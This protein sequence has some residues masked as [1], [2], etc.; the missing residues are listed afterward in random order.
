MMEKTKQHSVKKNFFYS[1]ILTV[2]NYLFPMIVFPYVSRVLGVTNIG[3]CNFVDSIVNYFMLFSMMGITVMGIREI[4]SVKSDRMEMSRSF[5]SLIVI[6]GIFT[7]LS[8]IALL[9]TAFTVESLQGYRHL[10]FISL[11]KLVGNFLLIEWFFKGLEDFKF[12]TNRT[13]LVKL[14]YVASVFIFV[15]E[16]DDYV[17]YYILSVMMVFVN[18]IFNGI[19]ASRK[20]K[21]TLRGIQIKKY[22]NP[23]LYLGLYMILT[24]MYTSF[25][26]IYLGFVK[27][28]AEVGF[29]TTAT[30][31]YT[32]IL[33]LFTAF[34]SVM[35][36]RMSAL[37]SEKKED[38]FFALIHKSMQMLVTLGVPVVL[39]STLYSSQ[40]IHILAGGGFEGAI[41]P[42]RIVMPLMLIIGI[43][44]ILVIQI[45]MPFKQ[46]K[47]IF[48]NAVIGAAVGITLNLALVSMLGSTGSAIVWVVS[49]ISVLLLSQ[50]HVSRMYSVAFPA[51][52]LFKTMIAY[53]PFVAISLLMPAV[54]DNEYV[55]LAI[56]CIVLAV[57]FVIVQFYVMP[58]DFVKEA[59]SKMTHRICKS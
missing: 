13:I 33:S 45:M 50:M 4:S 36:P 1:S 26:V 31:L 32:I 37:L 15:R 3:I 46:D 38:E 34:T 43:E 39:L 9:V 2:S 40:I 28:D 16:Q 19:Y 57:N 27:G 59:L 25:N 56:A 5:F 51:A 20:V 8:A 17:V 21:F 7:V 48:R 47:V 44:Q 53:L 42:A 14:L 55:R 24:N 22:M 18:A 29:Y 30:K 11:F 58:D 23:F 41:L 6:N 12:I 49:E 52:P 54:L 35:L 10:L